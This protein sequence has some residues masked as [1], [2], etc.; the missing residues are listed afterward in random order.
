[1]TTDPIMADIMAAIGVL[2]GGDR[3]GG[4]AKLEAIWSRI[5]GNPQP[6]HEC[7]LA[8]YM[9]DAQDDIADEL[10]WDLR[11]LDA[12]LRSTDADARQHSSAPS[13]AAFMPSLHINLSEDYF[14]LGDFA[15]SRQHLASARDAA[16]HLSDDGYGRMLRGS[17][18]RLTE[19]LET[20]G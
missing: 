20:A 1:M 16:H 11:A 10:A 18:D 12:G 14:K 15:R 4:K 5:A 7:T 19:K 6:I 9:A 2:L 3:A 13:I 8:H 17:I